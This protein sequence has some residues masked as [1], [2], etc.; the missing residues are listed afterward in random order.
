M[1][2]RRKNVNFEITENNLNPKK[3]IISQVVKKKQRI[4]FHKKWFNL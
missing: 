3:D 4:K 2:Q 1:T